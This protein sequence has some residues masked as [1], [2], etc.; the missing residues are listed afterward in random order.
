MNF[1]TNIVNRMIWAVVQITLFLLDLIYDND[2]RRFFVLETIA[3]IPYISYLSVLH[4]YQS[5]GRHPSYELMRLHFNQSVNE[6]YHLQ[7]MESL[8]GGNR[9]VDRAFARTL[10]FFYYW[11]NC[12]LYLLFPHSGYYLME[13]VEG[14]A[15][16]TYNDF[17]NLNK[18]KLT[19]QPANEVCKEYFISA[20]ARMTDV[21]AEQTD[22]SLYQ[23]FCSIRDDEQFHKKEMQNCRTFTS[24][25]G[26]TPGRELRIDKKI[27]IA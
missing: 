9:W 11:I 13:L 23:I 14:H 8:G 25:R 12:L 1:L 22:I 24:L 16:K 7:I 18:Q 20:N 2:Y 5:F 21:Q 6:E 4:L 15:A 26:H 3:R 10:S 17:L 27:K 19:G